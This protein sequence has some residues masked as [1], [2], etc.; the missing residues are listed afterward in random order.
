MRAISALALIVLGCGGRVDVQTTAP[1]PDAGA[2]EVAP[3]PPKTTCTATAATTLAS[4]VSPYAIAIDDG[5]VYWSDGEPPNVVRRVPKGGGPVEDVAPIGGIEVRVDDAF[6]YAGGSRA[7]KTGGP[8][9]ELAVSYSSIAS[10]AID[11]TT[12][13]WAE[14]DTIHANVH[15][16]PLGGGGDV[17]L[18][19][20]GGMWIHVAA[21]GDG[22]VYVGHSHGVSRIDAGGTVSQLTAPAQSGL[23]TM[24]T[25]DAAD[26]YFGVQSGQDTEAIWSLSKTGGT[27]TYLGE[28]TTA[29]QLAVDD[30]FLYWADAGKIWRVAKGG[31]WPEAIGSYAES[32]V[33]IGPSLAVDTNCVY[34]STLDSSGGSVQAAPKG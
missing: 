10:I 29:R 9:T 17:L 28:A 22:Y 31:G 3:P 25:V 23:V 1:P 26:V 12:F 32:A 13:F 20:V 5:Y 7:P 18:G 34:W 21:D 30:A 8:V 6:V 24:I 19:D 4:H 16:V 27:G 33:Y 15:A 11:P 14:T 2:P